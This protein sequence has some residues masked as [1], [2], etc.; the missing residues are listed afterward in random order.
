MS[1]IL[2]VS[3]LASVAQLCAIIDDPE[4]SQTLHMLLLYDYAQ[5]WTYF[6]FVCLFLEN[7]GQK[8]YGVVCRCLCSPHFT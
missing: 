4:R 3:A 7:L 1:P 8:S 6:L 5:V 2:E